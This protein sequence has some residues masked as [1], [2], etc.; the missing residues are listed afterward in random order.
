MCER[1]KDRECPSSPPC[2][3]THIHG[4]QHVSVRLSVSYLMIQ[5]VPPNHML[6]HLVS[7]F[8]SLSSYCGLDESA[9][10]FVQTINDGKLTLANLK[11]CAV[12]VTCKMFS[13]PHLFLQQISLHGDK[14]CSAK[15][16]TADHLKVD[17]SY[18]P[19]WTAFHTSCP[20]R[21][22]RHPPVGPALESYLFWTWPAVVECGTTEHLQIWFHV[23]ITM[24]F[25]F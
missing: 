12:L 17:C 13:H 6:L 9:S 10:K 14:W 20:T 19:F 16:S 25:I 8:H 21:V 4:L 15:Q 24:V 3:T 5:N 18:N 23:A 7:V 1:G 22:S 11:C 2:S